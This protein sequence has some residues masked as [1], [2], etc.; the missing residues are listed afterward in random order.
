MRKRSGF[1]LIELLVVIA[2]IAILIG[3]LLPAVQKVRAAAARM[4]SQN[5]LKQ[6]GIACHAYH[7]GIGL[8]P[9]DSVAV[10]VFTALLPYMEQGNQNPAS[11]QPIKSYLDP[12]RRTTSV[13]AKDDYGAAHHPDWGFGQTGAFS[14]LGAIYAAGGKTITPPAIV[15]ITDGTSN[16]FLMAIKG[17][18]PRNYAGG[19]DTGDGSRLAYG[20]QTDISWADGGSHWEHKRDPQ[21]FIQDT[22]DPSKT[23]QYYLGGPHTGGAPVSMSDGSVRIVAY[24]TPT[25][26]LLAGWGYNDGLITNLP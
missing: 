2:I 7:D 5:N 3:L 25:N 22:N 18:A 1:T 23:M 8:F 6:M 14:V 4:Q 19:P 21:Y 12:A 10:T 15:G 24:G 16:T 20:A 26:V 11:P 13:G 9:E 17:M